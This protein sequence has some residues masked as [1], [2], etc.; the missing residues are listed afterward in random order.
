MNRHHVHV[1][2][3]GSLKANGILAQL[4][5]EAESGDKAFNLPV[6]LCSAPYEL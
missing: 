5:E 3:H 2:G 6:I 4:Q 1:G